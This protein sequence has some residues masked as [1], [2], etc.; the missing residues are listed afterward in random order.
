MQEQ[1]GSRTG[2]LSSISRV[3]S[4]DV[5]MFQVKGVEVELRKQLTGV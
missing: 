1:L 2:E 4:P 5:C 3:K